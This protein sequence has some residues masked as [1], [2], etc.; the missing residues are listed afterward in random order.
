MNNIRQHR[1]CL[2]GWNLNHKIDYQ[3]CVWGQ[4]INIRLCHFYTLLSLSTYHVLFSCQECKHWIMGLHHVDLEQMRGREDSVTYVTNIPVYTIIVRLIPVK[5]QRFY[6]NGS[7][8]LVPVK[9]QRFYVNGSKHFSNKH[10]IM[11]SS[12]DGYTEICKR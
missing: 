2:G 4:P 8:Q 6:M 11:F 9:Q 5:Q 7:K 10:V 1:D 3:D 12:I